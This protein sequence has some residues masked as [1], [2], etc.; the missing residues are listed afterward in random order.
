MK[1]LIYWINKR[2]RPT[3]IEA[4]EVSPIG[5]WLTFRNENGMIVLAANDK[6]IRYTVHTD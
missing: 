2:H 1:Y 5:S 4:A 6:Q 3:S